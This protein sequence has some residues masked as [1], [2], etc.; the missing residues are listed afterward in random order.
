MAETPKFDPLNPMAQFASL[1]AMLGGFFDP[2]KL[3]PMGLLR[4][5]TID[6]KVQE[7]A[8]IAT[9]HNMASMLKDSSRI[10]AVLSAELA[11]RAKKLD[12]R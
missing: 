5:E 7:I 8:I 1:Q 6:P 12:E 9:M 2:M 4:Y 3:G 10:K 11:E